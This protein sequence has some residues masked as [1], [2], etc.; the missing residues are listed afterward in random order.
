MCDT[1]LVGCLKNLEKHEFVLS[2]GCLLLF[3]SM[4]LKYFHGSDGVS[5]W[6]KLM[7]IY[8]YLQVLCTEVSSF[9]MYCEVCCCLH[10]K[11]IVYT[12]ECNV[13]PSK[14]RCV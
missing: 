2:C 8:M 4:S 6:S 14:P 13:G 9:V 5:T 10:V 11:Y 7:V 1:Y 3:T 12:H